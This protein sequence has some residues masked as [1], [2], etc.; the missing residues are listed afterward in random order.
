MISSCQKSDPTYFETIDN[1]E[2]IILFFSDDEELANEA[3]YYDAFLELKT[4]Y[5]NE[6]NNLKVFT[7]P[8]DNDYY[9]TFEISTCPSVIV[10]YHDEVILH[11]HGNM[12]KDEIV[13]PLLE[14]LANK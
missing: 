13:E 1:N 5:P 8:Q 14:V 10:L 11:L 9:S 4:E 12:Q 3:A 6:I 2:K 7:R